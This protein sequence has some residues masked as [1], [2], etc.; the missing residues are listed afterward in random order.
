MNM[1]NETAFLL[2]SVVLGI[3]Y[4]AMSDPSPLNKSGHDNNEVMQRMSMYVGQW[5]SDTKTN[6]QNGS[7][8]YYTY[9]FTYFNTDKTI[10]KMIISQ[11]FEE[12][13]ESVLWEGY[14]G[15][16]PDKEEVYYYGFSPS[17]RFSIGNVSIEGKKLITRY[18]GYGPDGVPAQIVDEFYPIENDKFRSITNLKP[19]DGEWRVIGRDEWTKM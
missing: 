18:T 13:K 1:K 19:E 17:G 10:Y 15:W 12:G 14:K 5:K 7:K 9:N 6:R 11:H 4:T 2:L 3:I 16:N 8:F